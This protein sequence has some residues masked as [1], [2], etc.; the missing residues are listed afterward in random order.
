[1]KYVC[2]AVLEDG[3]TLDFEIDAET[4]KFITEKN[5]DEYPDWVSEL[6][7]DCRVC[8][9]EGEMCSAGMNIY[10]IISF[11]DD[12]NSIQRITLTYISSL[13]EVLTRNLRA[14][15]G[16]RF[17]FLAALSFSE[18]PI[19][20]GSTWAW[21][22]YSDYINPQRLF[23]MLISARLVAQAVMEDHE[24]SMENAMNT[25]HKELKRSDDVFRLILTSIRELSM[26]DA[27]VNAL[28]TLI[29]MNDLLEMK[30][31]DYIKELKRE[32][33]QSGKNN[34]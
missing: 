18:C 26:Q 11:F 23:Y 6:G 21:K 22:Y 30:S 2:I 12:V 34:T 32:I 7:R 31:E 8:K 17:I 4:G 25:V 20:S 14:S 10:K 1:M 33:R 27:N 24:L 3:R 5:Q 9:I 29:H 13:G 16:L 15:D 19:F 28:T